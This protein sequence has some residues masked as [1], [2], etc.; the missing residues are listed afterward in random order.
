M[1]THAADGTT[2]ARVSFG[3]AAVNTPD[4]DRYQRFYEDVLGLTLAVTNAPADTPFRRIGAFADR[5]ADHM[6]L[7]VFE[8]PGYTSPLPDDQIGQ[9]GRIDHLTFEA[10]DDAA[11]AEILARL[12]D[13][14]A[15]DGDVTPLG[16][17]RSALFIDPDGAHGNLQVTVPDWRPDP[18]ADVS[19]A[20]LVASRVALDS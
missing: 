8:I 20:N 6:G 4:L 1:N 16:P 19:D 9:R 5:H 11:F 2:R 14:G 18:D 10:A 12:V 3:H 7:L 17:V 13:A 15:S